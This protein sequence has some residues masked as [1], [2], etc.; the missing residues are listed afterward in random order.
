MNNIKRIK[1]EEFTTQNEAVVFSEKLKNKIKDNDIEVFKVPTC[2]G[3][4]WV[5]RWYEVQERV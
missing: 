2:N 1:N 5:V 3:N 4:V